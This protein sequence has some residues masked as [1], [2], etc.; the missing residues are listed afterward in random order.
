MGIE[1]ETY[2]VDTKVLDTRYKQLMAK[3]HPDKFMQKSKREQELSATQ[4]SQVNAAYST[5]RCPHKRAV[6]MLRRLGFDFED[7]TSATDPE[8]MMDVMEASSEIQD[9][10]GDQNAIKRV[11]YEF[12][13]PQ[14]DA[15]CRE[16][17]EAFARQDV[18]LAAEITARLQYL[19]RLGNMI[20][21]K[22][23]VM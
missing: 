1:G 5:L 20:Q 13:E 17:A 10:A 23:E 9:A 14:L 21:E 3:I 4:C 19:K 2:D 7:Q 18:L 12:Y 15:N 16:A 11:R 22:E 8:F 6:Y